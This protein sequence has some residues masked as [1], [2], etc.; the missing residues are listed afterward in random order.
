MRT[1]NVSLTQ[2]GLFFEATTRHK[3]EGAEAERVRVY[4]KIRAG[5]WAHN[6]VFSLVDAWM[7]S[8]T[9]QVFKFR[10]VLTD[11]DA[12]ENESHDLRHD[13]IIPS[14]VKREV[15]KRDGGRCVIC[16]STDNLHFDHDIPFSRGG[17][18]ITPA[19]CAVDVREPQSQEEREDRVSAS[20]QR[21]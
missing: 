4:E 20:R 16:G 17:S 2:N 10:L 8:G 6:G 11:D 21:L 19:N 5:I 1:P 18:S 3:Q 14:A 9:R 12:G 15:W 7:A 13:R